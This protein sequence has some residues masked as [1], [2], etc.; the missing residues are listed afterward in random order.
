MV[1]MSSPKMEAIRFSEADVIV[2]STQFATTLT[3]SGL[4]DRTPYNASFT[5]DTGITLTN[6]AN[7]TSA[8]LALYN[9]LS[10]EFTGSNGNITGD[11]Y[12]G[13]VQFKALLGSNYDAGGNATSA[14]YADN[15]TFRWDNS[16]R[17][18]T[19]N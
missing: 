4:Q 3:I 12:L 14:N 18:F 9:A 2:A 19:R 7:T 17:S 13:N 5:T 16:A 15:T 1:R 6:T 11:T 10:R 8:H